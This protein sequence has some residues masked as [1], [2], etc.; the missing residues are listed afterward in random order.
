MLGFEYKDIKKDVFINGYKYLDIIGYHKNYI[1]IINNLKLYLVEF[2]KNESMKK[3]NSDDCIIKRDK[4][5]LVIIITHND[6]IFFAN[7]EI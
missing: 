5:Q 1:T 7:N 4:Y 2:E 3:K 6:R